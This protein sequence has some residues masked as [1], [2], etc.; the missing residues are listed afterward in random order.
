M[1]ETKQRLADRLREQGEACRVLGSPLYADLLDRAAGDVERGG[2]TL[3]VLR[4]HVDDPWESMLPLRLLGSVHRLVLQGA[5][6]RLAAH[7]A[8]VSA[9]SSAAWPEFLEVVAAHRDDLTEL[10]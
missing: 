8:T 5:A 6:P 4:G 10:I 3:E 9:G 7:Y 2:P 1:D